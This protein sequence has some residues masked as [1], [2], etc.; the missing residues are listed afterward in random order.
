MSQRGGFTPRQGDNTPYKSQRGAFTPRGS[1]FTPRG[2]RG[3][4]N[5]GDR[6]ARGFNTPTRGAGRPGNH[7]DFNSPTTF[8]ATPTGGNFRG[9]GGRGGSG[10]GRGGMDRSQS[11]FHNSMLEDPWADLV[12][13]PTNQQERL[14]S[15]SMI[16][17]VDDSLQERLLE[18]RGE[19]SDEDGGEREEEGTP[20]NPGNDDSK[21]DSPADISSSQNTD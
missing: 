14:L 1:G 6:G 16:P 5:G 19:G 20:Q 9:G 18:D 11:W 3:G 21:N 4:F 10:R 7:S 17:Q 8:A 15:D 12:R 2:G 13:V